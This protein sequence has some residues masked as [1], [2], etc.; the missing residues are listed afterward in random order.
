MI[1]LP[2]LQL[3]KTRAEKFRKFLL[4]RMTYM[5]E[6]LEFMVAGGEPRI[7]RRNNSIKP[8]LCVIETRCFFCEVRSEF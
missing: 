1:A 7:Q 6:T 2:K 5:P 4:D 8:L 3:V